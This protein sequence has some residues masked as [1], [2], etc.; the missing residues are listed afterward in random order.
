MLQKY[1]IGDK[2]IA[3]DDIIFEAALALEMQGGK[4]DRNFN[5]HFLPSPI[6]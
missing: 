3:S 6:T 4:R 5:N 1:D 2:V